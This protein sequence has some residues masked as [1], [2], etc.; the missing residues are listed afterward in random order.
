MNYTLHKSKDI[1]GNDY[2]FHPNKTIEELKNICDNMHDAIG[3]NSLGYI[4]KD[5]GSFKNVQEHIN[6]YMNQKRYDYI[7][8]EKKN[9]ANNNMKKN[10]TFVTTT[11]K[12]LWFCATRQPKSAC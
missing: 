11:C 10:I 6:F 2:V 3:F 7:L 8:Q 12:R 1:I 9:I 4:K 5:I